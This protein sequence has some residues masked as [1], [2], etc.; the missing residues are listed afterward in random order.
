[1]KGMV[2]ARNAC[3]CVASSQ[4]LAQLSSF[5]LNRS[6]K[7]SILG[8][9]HAPLPFGFAQRG[10]AG[11]IQAAMFFHVTVEAQQVALI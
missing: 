9:R 4:M 3:S 6:I 5:A 11:L 1:M 7:A 8:V 10:T 2:D